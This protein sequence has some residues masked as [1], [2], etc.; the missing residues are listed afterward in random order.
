[1][2]LSETA[3]QAPQPANVLLEV[4]DLRVTFATPDGDVTAV[5]DLNFT[6]RAGETLGIVGESGSGKSQTAFALMGLLATNGRIGGSATFNGRE[7]LNLPERELNT[8]RAEQI[9]MIFQDPMTSL[10]PYMRVGEQLMEVLM[11]HKGMSKAEAFEE[12]VRMLDA[13]KMPEARKRMKM[14][15]HEFSGGMRQRVM[16]AMALLCRPKLLI[17]DEP[18]TALDVTV[19]AQIMTL[20]NELKREFNTAIIMITHDLGVVGESGCGKSTFARAIIGLVKATDGKVAWLG[21]DLLGMKADEWRE[22]RSDIQMIFQDPLASLNPRMTI[23]E[24]IAEPLRTYHPKLSRQDVRDRVKA[25]MLK[26]GLLPNLIN[27]YPHEFSG[28]Q[29]QRIGIARALILEPKLIICDEPVSALDVSIQAQVVNLLQQLQREMGLSLIF[30]AHDL[31]VVKHISDRVLVMYLGHAVELGTYDE[32]YHNPLHPYTKALMSA[33][34]IPDPDLE[35]NKKIQLLEGEL[36]SPI[37]PPSGCV[38]RTRCPI[39]GPEC[40]QTRPVL[41]G[42]FRHAVSCLKVDPL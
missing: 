18:T 36:P 19:Q 15:P 2:S 29:C 4:N 28:G 8:L 1:M 27:R 38:F 32:V 25:M 11:L 3:T 6:L 33:V 7:I 37:N 9:S 41:E 23:G 17:A 14:Y 31:A 5:N 34:P 16:I 39:A 10:N 40:A 12:S 20:L 22:V 42:S 13:V 30:I 35:R 24:I 26:V 21:K